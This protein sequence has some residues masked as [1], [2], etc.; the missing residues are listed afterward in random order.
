M[1][2]FNETDAI[3]S[4]I[5]L[6]HSSAA[7]ADWR[8]IFSL[9]LG[10]GAWHQHV[11]AL[12]WFHFGYWKNCVWVAPILI[13]QKTAEQTLNINKQRFQGEQDPG[14]RA[15]SVI[16]QVSTA[17]GLGTPVTR[18]PQPAWWFWISKAVCSKHKG[19]ECKRKA[20]TKLAMPIMILFRVVGREFSSQ[21]N[22][23][24]C[25]GRDLLKCFYFSNR[26]IKRHDKIS[27]KG[28]QKETG[29]LWW[30]ASLINMSW[31]I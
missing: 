24:F 31:S 25:G 10:D 30:K 19:L 16:W 21:W 4:H 2:L 1:H 11:L 14:L 13:T 8:K 18:Y 7:K 20:L 9:I 26:G 23:I 28:F 29:W 22:A 3:T 15:V 12:F 5:W 6:A 17:L 27:R